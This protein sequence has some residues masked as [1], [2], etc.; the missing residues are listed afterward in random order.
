MRGRWALQGDPIPAIRRGFLVA[1]PIGVALMARF[2]LDDEIAGAAATAALVCGFIAFDAPARVRVRWQ[3]FCAPLVGILAAL[4][5]LS[6][7]TVPTAIVVMGVVAT[8]C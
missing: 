2:E 3:L 8:L 5:T 6:S 7:Q 4:G 1:A